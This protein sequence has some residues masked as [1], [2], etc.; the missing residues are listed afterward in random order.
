M[1]DERGTM[2]ARPTIVRGVLCL[3]PASSIGR[4]ASCVL[5]DVSGRKVFDL[6]PGANDVSRL[7][8]GVYFVRGPET[9]DGK[10]SAAVTKVATAK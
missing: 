10:P 8:P 5:L 4:D 2:N 3:P 7:A 6:R 9:G 1:N